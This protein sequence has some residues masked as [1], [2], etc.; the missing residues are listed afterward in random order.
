MCKIRSFLIS[1]LT[2]MPILALLAVGAAS[3][4]AYWTPAHAGR[5]QT[6]ARSAGRHHSRHKGHGHRK[7]H[8]KG[9]SSLPGGPQGNTGLQGKTGPAGLQGPK[10]N[11]GPVGPQGPGAI[12]YAYD[13]TAPAATEQNTPLGPSG[14]FDLTGSCV[15]L[16]PKLVAVTLGASNANS[17]QFDQTRTEEDD[18]IPAF[19]TFARNTQPQSLTPVALFGLASTSLGTAYSYA[20][21]RLTVT[22]PVHGE[23]EVFEYVSE[24]SN[25]CHISTVWTPAS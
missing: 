14:P 3:A 12:G 25:I 1:V 13:S 17:V 21:G 11:P 19:T 15:Q 2:T 6:I 20:T 24:V 7:G 18:G 16:G 8:G 10:G 5:S 23:L 22:S 4:N 9:G